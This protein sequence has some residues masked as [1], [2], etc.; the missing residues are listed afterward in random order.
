MKYKLFN[1]K[2]SSS[3]SD[4]PKKTEQ[5]YASAETDAVRATSLA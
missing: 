5:R 3:P 4:H 2:S 1:V